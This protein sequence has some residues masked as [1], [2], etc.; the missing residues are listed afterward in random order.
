MHFLAFN[1]LTITLS[2]NQRG[3][4]FQDFTADVRNRT[5]FDWRLMARILDERSYCR[6]GRI[7]RVGGRDC[8]RAAPLTLRRVGLHAT[9]RPLWSCQHRLPSEFHCMPV[10]TKLIVGA[11][12]LLGVTI[13]VALPRGVVELAVL[14]NRRRVC[15]EHRAV[16]RTVGCASAGSW[17]LVRSKLARTANGATFVLQGTSSGLATICD[18]PC[19][20]RQSCRRDI[21]VVVEGSVAPSGSLHAE[22]VLTRCASKYESQTE[23]RRRVS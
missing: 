3:R 2:S 21:A 4:I 9:V 1:R 6:D 14:L 22:K 10:R 20:A 13:Y 15:G 23:I 12:V 19:L 7:I 8:L 5:H 18:G 17:R 11:L 16:R